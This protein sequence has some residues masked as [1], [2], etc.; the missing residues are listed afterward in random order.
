MRALFFLLFVSSQLLAQDLKKSALDNFNNQRWEEAVKD[1]QKYL[2]KDDR[3]SSAWY[4]LAFSQMQ[5]G[6]YSEAIPN[7]EKAKSQK[8]PASFVDFSISKIYAQ[9]N[10]KEKLF[11]T[12]EKG[13]ENGLASYTQLNTDKVFDPFRSDSRFLAVLEKVKLNAYP[14]LKIKVYRHFDFWLGE[15][16]VLANGRKVGDNSITMAQ[17]GCAIHESYTTAGNYAGQSINY[18]DPV[19]KK[20]HQHWVGSGGDVYNYL[21]TKREEGMLQFESKFSNWQGDISLSRLTFT[22]NEDGTVRQFFESST[23][24]GKTWTPAFDGLYKKK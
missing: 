7:F 18:F 19:D 21:E 10:N 22:L 2:K 9:Q 3:D 11:S 23:D 5:L 15:W 6:K 13:A 17:G 12:L 8:F 24:E 20:W 4:N 1:Y 16:E 14:C